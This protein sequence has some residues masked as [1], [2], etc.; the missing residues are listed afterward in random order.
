MAGPPF[1]RDEP[2]PGYYATRGR[3]A[4]PRRR[5]STGKSGGGGNRTRV[6]DRT[7]QSVYKRSLRFD[8]ARRPVRRRPTDGPAIL[9]SRPSGDWL[10]FGASPFYDTATRIT[11]RIRSDASPSV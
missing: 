1:A 2:A 10:S 4:Q 6:R 5:R 11:G 9:V 3:T 7:G 8:L